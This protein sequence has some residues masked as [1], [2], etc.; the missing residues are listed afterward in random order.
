MRQRRPE[1][2]SLTRLSRHFIDIEFTKK[3]IVREEITAK[4]EVVLGES[5]VYSALLQDVFSGEY[6]R[7][8]CTNHLLNRDLRIE[9]EETYVVEIGPPDGV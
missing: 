6:M 5:C 2:T 4:K 8:I 1:T 9:S 3:H 7:E